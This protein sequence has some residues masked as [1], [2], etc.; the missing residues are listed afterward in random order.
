MKRVFIVSFGNWTLDSS[1]N[2]KLHVIIVPWIITDC[3][4][5]VV[6]FLFRDALL[7]SI[8]SW[9]SMMRVCAYAIIKFVGKYFG[10]NMI[11]DKNS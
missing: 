5:D 9:I 6:F 4:A 1:T 10:T 11:V 2:T 7:R 3:F 8:V